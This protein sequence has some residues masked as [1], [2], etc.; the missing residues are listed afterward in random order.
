[1]KV[2]IFIHGPKYLVLLTY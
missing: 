2:Y 1:M